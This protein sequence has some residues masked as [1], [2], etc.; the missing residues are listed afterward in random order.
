MVFDAHSLS[1]QKAKVAKLGS[2]DM[3]PHY[4][5]NRYGE[6]AAAVLVLHHS[7]IGG[8]AAVGRS[9]GTADEMLLN[10]L[11]SL[12]KEMVKLLT[13]MAAVHSETKASM[14]FLINNYHNIL[15]IFSEKRVDSDEVERVEELLA[16][17]KEEFVE[18]ELQQSYSKLIQFVKSTESAGEGAK[19]DPAL[20]EAL[21]RNFAA[22]WKSGIEL[23]NASVR[24]YF[25]EFNIGMGIL[26]QVLTQLLLYYT[27]FQEII[28]IN[29][30][31]HPPPFSRDIVTTASILQEI[32]K[33]SQ[34]FQ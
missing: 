5:T 14:V 4:V 13:G 23:I 27:R 9:E 15:G 12:R 16:E 33:Y 8:A 6:F 28:R 10:S 20:V 31:G 1:V 24:R 22:S 26:K 11:A 21:V 17:Q 34:S 2:I 19:V 3:V 30:G 25:S 32:K 29:W 18:E 7:P